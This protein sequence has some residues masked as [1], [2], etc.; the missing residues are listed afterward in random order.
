MFI[1]ENGIL[2]GKVPAGCLDEESGSG[3]SYDLVIGYTWI[4]APAVFQFRGSGFKGSE[5][6]GRMVQR[7]GGQFRFR[8][9]ER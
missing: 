1:F 5:V 9:R 3:L 6:P 7:F 4:S 8:K 2:K